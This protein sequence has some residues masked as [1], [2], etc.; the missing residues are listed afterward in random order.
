MKEYVGKS[1]HSSYLLSCPWDLWTKKMAKHHPD[2]IF[3]RK[4]PGVGGYL[5]SNST[6]TWILINE[7]I[8]SYI[9]HQNNWIIKLIK[10]ALIKKDRLER[11]FDW[12]VS[13]ITRKCFQDL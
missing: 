7:D 12:P 10:L 3:C 9:R 4:Q 1:K 5:L 13:D 11:P 2:L 8:K 6:G